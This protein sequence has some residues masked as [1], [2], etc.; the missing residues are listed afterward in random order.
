MLPILFYR[1]KDSILKIG[2][3]W[4]KAAL[5]ETN[6]IEYAEQ[7][8]NKEPSRYHLDNPNRFSYEY[9]LASS[10]ES[11]NNRYRHNQ[12]NATDQLISDT[13]DSYKTNMDLIVYRGVYEPIFYLMK[14]NAKSHSGI[15][16]Y[17]KGFM[18]TSL[19]KNCELQYKTK[20]RIFVPA[21][22]K[23]IYMGNV[24]YELH[25]FYELT[26]QHDA[27][28]KIISIDKDY[29]NCKLVRTS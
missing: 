25:K 8:I 7:N 29:I 26:I 28:L 13:I 22:T 18:C 2:T 17:E 27:A 14:T 9:C 24:N 12:I 19:I 3:K 15:D 6:V 4:D 23:A 5:N 21:G 10:A 1:I 11:I 16:L 20:L